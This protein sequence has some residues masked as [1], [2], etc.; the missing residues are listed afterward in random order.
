MYK[1]YHDQ[2]LSFQIC[3]LTNRLQ[4]FSS[5]FLLPTLFSRVLALIQVASQISKGDRGRAGGT[6]GNAR[7]K[8]EEFLF[9]S[10]L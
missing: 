9:F 1:I 7:Q 6:L 2:P 8:E 5:R 3:Y 10:F 4:N